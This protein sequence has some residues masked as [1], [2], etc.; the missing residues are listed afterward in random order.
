M[1]C[2]FVI[3]TPTAIWGKFDS[4]VVVAE[5]HIQIVRETAKKKDE[6]RAQILQKRCLF[7]HLWPAG[8]IC[9]EMLHLGTILNCCATF[10]AC[11]MSLHIWL[12]ASGQHRIQISMRSNSADLHTYNSEAEP[13]HHNLLKINRPPCRPFPFI[14]AKTMN[15]NSYWQHCPAFRRAE[16]WP[17]P[18]W[19]R[20]QPCGFKVCTLEI[21]KKLRRYALEVIVLYLLCTYS[22]VGACK[23][24]YICKGLLC[25]YTAL[26]VYTVCLSCSRGTSLRTDSANKFF[27]Q[28]RYV[29]HT[30]IMLQDTYFIDV[31]IL[32]LCITDMWFIDTNIIDV[33]W[34]KLVLVNFAWVT[35]LNSAPERREPRGTKSG[36]PKE[37]Q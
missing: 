21:F 34:V 24:V 28:H 13:L 16:S 23:P 4:F 31:C 5:F 6:K 17:V 7:Q 22:C 3:G 15:C 35:W 20:S 36:G 18:N 37:L 32:D 25:L 9:P 30:Y 10:G 12:A 27:W 14:R 1:W 29:R 2:N 33:A 26:F 8:R 11:L 19:I